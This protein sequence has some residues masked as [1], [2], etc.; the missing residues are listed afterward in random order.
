VVHFRSLWGCSSVGRAPAWHAGGQGF[1][2]PQLHVYICGGATPRTPRRYALPSFVWLGRGHRSSPMAGLPRCCDSC[3][4]AICSHICGGATPRTPRRYP[5]ER[6]ASFGSRTRIVV[7]PGSPRCCLFCGARRSLLEHQERA[8]SAGL[9]V[10]QCSANGVD[11]REE[12]VRRPGGGAVAHHP[13]APDLAGESAEAATHLDSVLDQQ[14][15]T[16]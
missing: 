15:V 5:L 9:G 11:R 7:V 2:S 14:A 10:R 12:P 16:G 3:G 8:A 1:K 4:G 13:D 6:S